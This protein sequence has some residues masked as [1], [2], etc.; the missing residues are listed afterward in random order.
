MAMIDFLRNNRELIAAAASVVVAVL[1]VVTALLKRNTSHTIRHET[2]VDAPSPLARRATSDD[3]SPNVSV[4]GEFLCVKNDSF[5][6]SQIT[7]VTLGR[8][9][10]GM[11]AMVAA[12]VFGILAVG[13]W[14]SGEYGIAILLG[15]F[16]LMGTLV[17][18]MKGVY[19]VTPQGSRRIAKSL[20]PG[21]ANKMRKAIL[22]WRSG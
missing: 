10:N 11:V 6:R 15:V 16:A 21:E 22:R 9:I 1:G 14:S 18:S 20:F 7:G 17:A 3:L 8:G 2:I 19:L 4:V 12:P 13:A 5:H